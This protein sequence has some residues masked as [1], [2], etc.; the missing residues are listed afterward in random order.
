MNLFVSEN[1]ILATAEMEPRLFNLDFQLLSDA[2]LMLIAVLVLFF[3]LSYLFFNPARAFLQKRQ[4]K[5]KAELDD[6][7]E[8][9]SNYLLNCGYVSTVQDICFE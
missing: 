6:A 1:F 2:V 9:A 8:K 7:K 4:E 3:L 5:I